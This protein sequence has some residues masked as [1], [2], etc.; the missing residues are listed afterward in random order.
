[1]QALANLA[2][3]IPTAS[4]PDDRRNALTRFAASTQLQNLYWR[5]GTAS[6]NCGWLRILI[7]QIRT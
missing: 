2:K 3:Y 5:I 1:V 4:V 7:C 6:L